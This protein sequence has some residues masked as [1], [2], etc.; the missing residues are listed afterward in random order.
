MTTPHILHLLRANLTVEGYEVLVAEDGRQALEVLKDQ[1]PDLMIL[2]SMLPGLDGYEVARRAREFSAIPII[3]LTARSSEIDIIH[4]FDAGA[5]DY[6]TKPFSTNELLVRM[7]AVLRERVPWRAGGPP[8][9]R[10]G[11]LYIDYAQHRQ[12][13]RERDRLDPSGISSVRLV[14]NVGRVV[15]HEDI[16]RHV[17]GPEYREET[18]SCA[19]CSLSSP[20]A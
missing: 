18:E 2:D 15:L 20:K 4:G 12:G 8:T 14:S 1:T 11:A 17:C 9:L 3:M 19:S 7:R 10:A 6:L 16:L 13:R 5:D